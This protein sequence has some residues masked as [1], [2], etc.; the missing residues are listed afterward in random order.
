MADIDDG[1]A[2]N[3]DKFREVMLFLDCMDLKS[4]MMA[5]MNY[6]ADKYSQEKL[7]EYIEDLRPL[8]YKVGGVYY[9]D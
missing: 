8:R 3:N 2:F 5:F 6:Y 4:I 9:R 7:S 1:K